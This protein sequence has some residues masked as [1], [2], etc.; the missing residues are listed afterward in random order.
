[1]VLCM[2]WWTMK[3]IL[4]MKS[5]VQSGAELLPSVDLLVKDQV[6][7]ELFPIL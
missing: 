3:L 4:Q 2:R 6:L 1:M 5:L 7:D